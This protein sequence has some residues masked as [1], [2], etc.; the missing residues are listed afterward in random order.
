MTAVDP[1]AGKIGERRK[2]LFRREPARFKAAHLARRR[3][4]TRG[5]LAADNPAHRSIMA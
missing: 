3:S 2:V 5:R 1:F 4:E